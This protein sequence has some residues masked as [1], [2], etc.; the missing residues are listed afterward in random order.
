M[1]DPHLRNVLLNLS[2]WGVWGSLIIIALVVLMVLQ[3]CVSAYLLFG[4]RRALR[5]LNA[6]IAA[7]GAAARNSD[8][9]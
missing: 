3:G 5:K 7:K 1:I 9:L 6:Q 4:I 8:L 2:A